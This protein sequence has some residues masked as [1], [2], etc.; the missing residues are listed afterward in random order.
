MQQF[1]E[2][3]D[4]STRL[5]MDEWNRFKITKEKERKQNKKDKPLLHRLFRGYYLLIYT[6]NI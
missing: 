1:N 5:E 4:E 3:S 2:K 6:F